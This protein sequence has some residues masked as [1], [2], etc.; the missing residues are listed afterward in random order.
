MVIIGLLIVFSVYLF[1]VFKTKFFKGQRDHLLLNFPIVRKIYKKSLLVKFS[2]ALSILLRSGLPIQSSLDMIVPL[3]NNRLV[4]GKLKVAI[5]AI[6]NGETF[7]SALSD[8]KLFPELFIKMVGLGGKT[9]DL[10]ATLDKIS[11]ISDRE[12]N[13]SLHRIT[14]SIEPTLVIVLSVVV[15]AILLLVMLPLINIMASIG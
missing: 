13:R 7:E 14:V 2:R 1:M 3:M 9:G 5:L 8:T 15:G 11:E 10:E 6:E 12:L 4:Q